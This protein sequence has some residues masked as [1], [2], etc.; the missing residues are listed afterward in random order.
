MDTSAS[1]VEVG[2][3][4]ILPVTGTPSPETNGIFNTDITTN[5]M[6][7]EIFATS[8]LVSNIEF[9][10]SI[11]NTT[12]LFLHSKSCSAACNGCLVAATATILEES[13][14]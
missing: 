13:V 4:K 12:R 5:K 3:Y 11:P 14:F 7:E 9:F 2:A 6:V 1:V 8:V 10:S